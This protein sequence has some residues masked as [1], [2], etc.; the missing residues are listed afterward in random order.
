MQ[1]W[2]SPGAA[3]MQLCRQSARLVFMKPGAQCHMGQLGLHET[4]FPSGKQNKQT[5]TKPNKQTNK[6]PELLLNGEEGYASSWRLRLVP[7]TWAGL[8]TT[9]L[10]MSMSQQIL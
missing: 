7:G 4:P 2:C 5:K 10:F 8:H 1:P 9:S 3:L 6:Q